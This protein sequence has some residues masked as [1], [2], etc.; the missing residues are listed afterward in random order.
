[1]D[2][3]LDALYKNYEMFELDISKK[4]EFPFGFFGFPLKELVKIQTN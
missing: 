4:H 1:M 3:L 2:K